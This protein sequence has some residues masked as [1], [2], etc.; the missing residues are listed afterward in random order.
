MTVISY[1]PRRGQIIDWPNRNCKLCSGTGRSIIDPVDGPQFSKA[2]ICLQGTRIAQNLRKTW[3]YMKRVKPV[4]ETPLLDLIRKNAFVRITATQAV[5]AAH[6]KSAMIEYCWEIDNPYWWVE[7]TNDKEIVEAWLYTAKFL[8]QEIMDADVALA[9]IQA[10]SARS[11][12]DLAMRA[13]LMV[14]QVGKKHAANKETKTTIREA[15]DYRIHFDKPVWVVD[16]PRD[17][18]DNADILAY[19]DGL[20]EDLVAYNFVHVDLSNETVTVTSPAAILEI[21]ELEEAH[22]TGGGRLVASASAGS[23]RARATATAEDLMQEEA[24]KERAL[25]KRQRKSGKTRGKNR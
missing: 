3:G 14:I 9:E 5:L 20:M 15:I 21:D 19:S 17:N 23:G 18:L 16:S 10:D 6:L 13:N 22:P 4:G 12:K 2:C 25:G 1:N 7:V 24:E 8:G 11:V